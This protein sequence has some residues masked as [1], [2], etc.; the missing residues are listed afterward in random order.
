MTIGQ[1]YI[2]ID[3]PDQMGKKG[4]IWSHKSNVDLKSSW[5]NS[6]RFQALEIILCGSWFH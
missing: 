6:I 1:V 2:V 3:I 5:A 4:E